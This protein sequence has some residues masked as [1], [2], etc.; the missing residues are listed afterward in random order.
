MDILVFY[1]VPTYSPRLRRTFSESDAYWRPLSAGIC[2]ARGGM[3]G[4]AAGAGQRAGGAAAALREVEE[5][6]LLP[7]A[8]RPGGR[9]PNVARPGAGRTAPYRRTVPP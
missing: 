3:G 8:D 7:R 9:V 6:T 4:A 1:G 2:E 5:G